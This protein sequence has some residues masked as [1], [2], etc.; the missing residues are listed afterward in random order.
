[1]DT[2]A[3][4][5]TRPDLPDSLHGQLFLLAF[6]RPR[7][8]FDGADRWCFGL[9]LRA[10]MLSELYLTGRLVDVDGEPHRGAWSA[11][12]DPLLQSVFDDVGHG[13][14][15]SWAQAVAYGSQRDAAPAVQRQLEFA[16]WL[17]VHRRRL[18]GITTASKLRLHD[19]DSH[20]AELHGR[21]TEALMAAIDERETDER[22]LT[23]GVLGVAA[24]LPTVADIEE[25]KFRHYHF[26]L[27]ELVGQSIPPVRAMQKVIA[28]V[29]ARIGTINTGPYTS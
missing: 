18:L 13:K 11:A 12:A 10:A 4:K 27:E 23:I 20:V 8:R 22:M 26:E 6:D 2:A 14:G 1:M 21:V 29:G 19:D 5:N 7:A 28:I 16:D 17:S 24:G 3:V 9:A 15:L 25:E